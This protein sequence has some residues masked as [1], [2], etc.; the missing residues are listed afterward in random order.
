VTVM[1]VDLVRQRVAL[2]M[3]RGERVVRPAAQGQ[4][5]PASRQRPRQPAPGR[6]PASAPSS[7]T[8]A[9]GAAFN[10]LRRER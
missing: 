1:E 8:T 5:P 9:M 10:R 4:Q 3:R 7:S 2:T 6:P